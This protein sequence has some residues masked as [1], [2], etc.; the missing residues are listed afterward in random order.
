MLRNQKGMSLVEVLISFTILTFGVLSVLGLFPQILK[1]N[2]SVWDSIQISLMAQEKMDELLAN[3]TYLGTSYIYDDTGKV[4][5]G[6]LRWKGD[7]LP[8]TG[9]QA[10]RVEIQWIDQGRT[11][12]YVI[13]GTLSP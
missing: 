1:L 12:N 13:H 7:V 4:P 2:D 8:S 11:K 6:Y 9:P 5:N 3:N 10:I